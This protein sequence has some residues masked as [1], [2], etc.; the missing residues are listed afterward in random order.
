VATQAT[1]CAGIGNETC[2]QPIRTVE[3]ILEVTASVSGQTN[4]GKVISRQITNVDPLATFYSTD[5]PSG[6]TEVL[7]YGPG[8]AGNNDEIASNPILENAN[9]QSN[10]YRFETFVFGSLTGT[11]RNQNLLSP[12][13]FD[14]NPRRRVPRGRIDQVLHLRHRHRCALS[15]RHRVPIAREQRP[16]RHEQLHPELEYQGRLRMADSSSG[17]VRW[18]FDA[19]LRR[20]RRLQGHVPAR[21]QPDLVDTRS[22]R[23]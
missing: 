1:D 15:G 3:L 21:R 7:D 18:R 22:V 16:G 9:F 13:D 2:V 10:D 23:V 6:G 14:T 11:G 12:W 19:R 8:V 5:Y 17:R 20:R 4:S